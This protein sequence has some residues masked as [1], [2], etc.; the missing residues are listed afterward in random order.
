MSSWTEDSPTNVD[1]KLAALAE[2][3][4]KNLIIASTTQFDCDV[5]SDRSQDY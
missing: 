2:F 5:I 1:A 4:T 3:I